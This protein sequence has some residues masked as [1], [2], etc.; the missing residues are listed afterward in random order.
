MCECVRVCVCTLPVVN[1]NGLSLTAK[2]ADRW[3]L[4][5]SVAESMLSLAVSAK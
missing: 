4:C 3:A 5:K 1:K 2:E